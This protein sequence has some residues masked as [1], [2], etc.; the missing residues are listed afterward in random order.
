MKLEQFDPPGFLN[1][2]EGEQ[3]TAWS[4]WISRRMDASIAGD[5]AN[6]ANDSPR[7]QFYNAVKTDTADDKQTLVITW[8]AFPRNV[9]I[10]S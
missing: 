7:P 1:E 3:K 2:L 5:S 6:F 4:R 8:T 9:A 10:T